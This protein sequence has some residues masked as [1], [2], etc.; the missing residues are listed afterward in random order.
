[1]RVS[2]ELGSGSTFSFTLSSAQPGEVVRRQLARLKRLQHGPS[3]I[4]LVVAHLSEGTELGDQD[5]IEALLASVLRRDD[6]LFRKGSS[7]PL[8][9]PCSRLEIG[10]FFA[11]VER[12]LADVNRN[13][14]RGHLPQIK[15]EELGF[16]DFPDQE[17]SFLSEFDQ[18]SLAEALV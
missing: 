15:F 6:L 8:V 7:W 18:L 17:S 12:A 5:D 2:S 10:K 11:R 16:W 3:Q 1:M 9:L 13:R 4:C 14:R